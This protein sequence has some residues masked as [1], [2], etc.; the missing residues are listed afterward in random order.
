MIIRGFLSGHE[1]RRLLLGVG[2]CG[3]FTTF[4][5]FA[6]DIAR[7]LDSG[8]TGHAATTAALGLGI[9]LSATIAGAA[10]RRATG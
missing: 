9:G 10:T 7:D 4:S 2:F 5:T 1:S 3:A 8:S 6:V